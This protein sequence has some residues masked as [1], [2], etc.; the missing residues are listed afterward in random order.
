VTQRSGRCNPSIQ[1]RLIVACITA[2]SLA[3]AVLLPGTR[4]DAQVE[5][6][7]AATVMDTS[8]AVIAGARVTI[9][10]TSTGVTAPAVTSSAGTFTVV[11]LNPGDYTVVVEA[12]GFKTVSTALTVEVAKM[13]TLG[14]HLEPG[15]TSETVQVREADVLLNTT[16][17]TLGTTLEP[18]LVRT[19]PIEINGLARQIDSF[20]FLA[21]GVQGT[22]SSHTINGGV[23]YENEVQFNGVPVAFVDYAGN[24]TYINPPYESIDE[25]RVNSSTFDARYGLGQGAVTYSMA[26]GTNQLHGDAF[27]ILR[28]QLFDSDGF[29]PVRFAPDGHPVAPINQQN[30]YGFTLGGP[31][32]LPKLYNG[33][34][35]TFFHFSSDWFRQNQAQDSIGTVPTAAMKD[36]DFSGFVDADGV[37]I[38]IYDPQTGQQFPGNIIPK[39]RFSPLA[40]SILPLIPDPD[41]TGL[42][43]GLESNKSPAVPSVAIKQFLWAY[44]LDHTLSDRQSIHFSQWRDTVTSPSFTDAPIVPLSNSLQSAANNTQLG[45]G[46][47]LNYVRTIT[48]NLVVTVGA[49][50]IG[51][52]T[53][54]D[55]AKTGVK[56]GGVVGSTSFPLV[57]FDGQNA[58]THWGVG[59]GSYLE[60][61]QGGLTEIANRRL[62]LVFVNNWL[63][64]KGPNTFNFGG[65]FRRTYQD[66]VD[67][68]FCSGTFSF[69]QRTT[70]TPDSND[71]NFGKDGSSFASFLL[72]QADAGVRMFSNESYLRNKEFAFY[73]Q[74]DIKFNSRLTF[75]VGFRYDIMVPFTEKNNNIIFMNP[76]ESN[77]GAGGILGAATKFG[78]CTGCSGITR[79]DIHWKNFQPRVGVAYT[80]N[81]KTVIR[82]GF[83]M[84]Y[85]D[86][87]AYEYGTAETASFMGSLLA[88][89][90]GRLST[91]SD[92]PGYGSWDANPMP[93]PATTPFSPSIG[94]AGTIFNFPY[95][96]RQQPPLL[97]TAGS[98]GTAP[99]VSAWNAAVQRELPWN[100]F[101]TAAYVGNRAIHLPTTLE[102]SN[103]VNPS[104]LQYGPLLGELVTSPDAIAAGIK[105]PYPEFVQQFGSSAT[106]EQALSPFPQFAGYY[107]V[108][109]MDG[110]AFYN[111]LQ[112]QGE[113]RF[114]N[115]LSY[116][117]GFTLAKLLSN[118]AVGSGPQSPN[119]MNAYNPAPEYAA[120]YIDQKYATDFVATYRLPVGLGQRYLNS[121]GLLAQL[122]GGWQISGILTYSGGYP[123]GPTNS[124]N[125]L[126]VN[127]FDRPNIVPGVK[128]QTY[129]YGRSK[130]YLTGKAA[131][132]PIQFT[133][134]AFENTGPWALGDAVRAYAALR[135]PPLRIENFDAIKYFHIT[136]R[137]R[138]SLR[139]DYFNAFN[140]TQLPAPDTNSLSASFGLIN[141]LSSQ[142]SNRQGQA[143]FRVEF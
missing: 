80:V 58:P 32:I 129:N 64:T 98:V 122:A 137:V 46:F 76:D 71:P 111:A 41:R 27:E 61:C 143:T 51:Y 91:G 116:L 12:A 138:A 13:S 19:A 104:V 36:G 54:Q 133:T 69:S 115:G 55:N 134:D 15:A 121:K 114:S 96:H 34:N 113:K 123:M 26:S 90:Y 72:G 66:I 52:I 142:I 118:T 4:L 18:E 9:T 43:F 3:V 42:V 29:F 11:G 24:Q 127:G 35:R 31:V 75:N 48:P 97:P 139:V 5:N 94:N 8:G 100:M 119:G 83:Y 62:G 20:M 78:N 99:Y 93:L 6:G 131:E 33:R 40:T 109:E 30:N 65:Q 37:Q 117:A 85:L 140:R 124:Y 68:D 74:D 22:S 39:S 60:C 86:G 130:A 135:A 95:K 88:G 38:P 89:S 16:S 132:R 112:V 73:A 2:M 23:S 126:I 77:P 81:S 67:C 57:T 1:G 25:F 128:L 10:N 70:S 56:F 45:T 84:T 136:E 141:N 63:W 108:N 59:G 17:P 92:V 14:F 7:I 125:P 103:Q 105:V 53:L 50:W 28:N 47:L 110:T 107:P 82:S 21:P 120:S 87:G 102:L 44:T 79:A 101:I 106:V 49:D